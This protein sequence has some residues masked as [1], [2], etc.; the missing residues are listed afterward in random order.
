[1]NTRILKVE[2][3][4]ISNLI[5]ANSSRFWVLEKVLSKSYKQLW[6]MNQI[7]TF[8][9]ILMIL[10]VKP[11]LMWGCHV[12]QIDD[13]ISTSVPQYAKHTETRLMT[14]TERGWRRLLCI[15]T[16]Q[17]Q[18]SHGTIG[19]HISD[20]QLRLHMSPEIQYNTIRIVRTNVNDISVFGIH[21]TNFDSVL[22]DH[23]IC[24]R[25]MALSPSVCGTESNLV[26]WEQNANEVLQNKWSS[27]AI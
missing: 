18:R 8:Y 20:G 1:M 16:Y 15:Y 12:N 4:T 10:Y 7:Q 26:S 2:V 17:A 3:P 22:L 11:I 14:L 9:V 25:R 19:H 13:R 6:W 21:I 24:R 23:Y 5:C 27:I